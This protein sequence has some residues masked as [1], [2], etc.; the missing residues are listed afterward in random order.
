M[1]L[2][3]YLKVYELNEDN[4]EWDDFIF[5]KCNYFS[6]KELAEKYAKKFEIELRIRRRIAELCEGQCKCQIYYDH[7][8]KELVCINYNYVIALNAFYCD[9]IEHAEQI[10]DEFKDEL[11]W[12]ATEFK[13]GI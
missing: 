7:L 13:N 1:S 12:L 3:I 4:S 6:S 9:T 5:D 10:I 2:K 8:S 11:T